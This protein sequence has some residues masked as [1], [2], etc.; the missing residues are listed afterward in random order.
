MTKQPL[1][2]QEVA[3]N[4]A[5]VHALFDTEIMLSVVEVCIQEVIDNEAQ[6]PTLHYYIHM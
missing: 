4:V 6:P 1:R 3:E 5:F 2:T